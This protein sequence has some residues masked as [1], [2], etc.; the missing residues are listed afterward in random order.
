MWYGCLWGT[1]PAAT[2]LLNQQLALRAVERD[3][4]EDVKRQ[5]PVSRLRAVLTIYDHRGNVFQGPRANPQGAHD[6]GARRPCS[7]QTRQINRCTAKSD[8]RLDAVGSLKQD[9][10]V[11][12]AIGN[13]PNRPEVLRKEHEKSI[14]V[15]F[16]LE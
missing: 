16:E 10:F 3:P 9:Q 4:S 6:R 1:A 12:T 5:Q 15:R 7:C 2:L 13:E 11:G 8:T 14:V